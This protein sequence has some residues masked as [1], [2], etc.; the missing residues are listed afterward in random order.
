MS[1]G[2][3]G[4]ARMRLG[5]AGHQPD[6]GLYTGCASNTGYFRT[7]LHTLFKKPPFTQMSGWCG[8]RSVGWSV[9]V[10]AIPLNQSKIVGTAQLHLLNVIFPLVVTL[11]ACVARPSLSRSPH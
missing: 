6:I 8:E 4:R 9:C 11:S 10:R 7:V 3:A 5:A 1:N 2:N